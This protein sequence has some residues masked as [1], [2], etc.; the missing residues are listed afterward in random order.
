MGN[1]WDLGKLELSETGAK[2]NESNQINSKMNLIF[3]SFIIYL[4]PEIPHK[5]NNDK[6]N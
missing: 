6:Y 2:C 4:S 1:E 3:F 5:M